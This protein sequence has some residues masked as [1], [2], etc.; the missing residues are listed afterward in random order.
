M[1]SPDLWDPQETTSEG[2]LERSPSCAFAS[3]RAWL[4]SNLALVSF[5]AIGA[6]VLHFLTAGRYGYFRDEL[7]YAACGQHL[8]WG[9]VDHAPLIG[10]V[11]W[12][13]RRLLGDSLFSLRFFPAL[14]A[15]TKILLTGWMV[16]ELKGKRFA[17]LLA[18]TAMFFCPIY[19][20]MDNFLSMNSFEPLF[21]MGCAAIAM[22][23]AN[24]G[25]LRLWLLFSVVAGVGILNKH[26]MLCF[27]LGLLL[28]LIVST[29]ASYFRNRWIWI[30]ASISFGI[31]LPNLV[32]E[33]IHHL[34]TI[35]IL[36]IMA[37][38]KNAHV[39]WYDFIAQQALLVHPLAAPICV[40][41]LWFFLVT[42]DGR[43]YRF[44]GWTYVFLLLQMILLGGRIY[45]LAPAY[46]M[47]FASGAVWL[48]GQIMQ[49]RWAWAKQAILAPLAIGGM[50]AA[51]LAMPLLPIKD[52]VSYS[53]L[54]GVKKIHVENDDS[55]VAPQFFADMFG[56]REQVAAVASVYH[57]LALEDRTHC[58]ILAGNYGEA[59]AIDYFGSLSG[60]PRAISAHNNYYL[61]GPRAYSGDIVIAIGVR[62]EVLQSLFGV[63]QPVALV[64]TPYAIPDENNLPV[65]LCRR[66][67]MPLLLAWPQLKF[68]G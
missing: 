42:E 41:G 54:W 53:N 23:I 44:L 38:T 56:W 50:I 37:K 9:Y 46:P 2:V 29:G 33:V 1:D 14:S 40:L 15:G 35:E 62:L 12:F 55:G 47:L 22:R 28:G 48:E 21:W 45:Y 60:L 49:R 26:S 18:A 27:G 31:F 32:W 59:G 10:I 58:A 34:P 20:T 43:P 6:C 57:N 51:P 4:D 30:G 36:Q 8:A 64:N 66:P 11:S 65:Y 24:R 61:W 19:L 63:V 13:T 7:Y 67:R 16:R 5:V 39:P 25:S 52:A 3:V 68:F 17:Q